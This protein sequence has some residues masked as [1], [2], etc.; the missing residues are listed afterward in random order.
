MADAPSNVVRVPK[1]SPGAFNKNRPAGKLLQAQ[2]VH[3]REALIRHLEELAGVLAI[4]LKS[5]T[6]EGEVGAYTKKVTAILHPHGAK[7][8]GK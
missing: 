5:L 6:T 1:P 7:H 2:T 3:L 8:P 4:D